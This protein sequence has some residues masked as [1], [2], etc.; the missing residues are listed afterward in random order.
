MSFNH[1]VT[2]CEPQLNLSVLLDELS[3]KLCPPQ[4]PPIP[5]PREVS[6]E[7]IV[8]DLDSCIK[9][10]TE[11]QDKLSDCALTKLELLDAL[12]STLYRLKKAKVKV[13]QLSTIKDIHF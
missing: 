12:E 10:V 3:L 1:I 6:A 9:T 4:S 11:V 8:G 5:G 7:S 2:T 13:V